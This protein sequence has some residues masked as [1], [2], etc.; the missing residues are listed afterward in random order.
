MAKLNKKVLLSFLLFI[1]IGVFLSSCSDKSESKPSK[2]KKIVVTSVSSSELL[3][4]LDVDDVIGVPESS[5]YSLPDRYK[6]KEVIGGPMSP[7]MEKIASLKP[8]LIIS[9]KSLESSLKEKYDNLGIDYRFIN[10]STVDGMYDSIDE[11]GVLLDREEEAKKLRS[12]YESKLESINKKIGNKEKPKVLVLMGVPG[13]YLV[14]TESS[15]VGDLVRLAGGENVYGDG[16]GVDFLNINTEDMVQKKADII[17][18]AAHGAPEQVNAM[19]KREFAE[20]DIWKHFDAVKNNK[21]YDLNIKKFGMSATLSYTEA[22]D[23]LEGLLF[24]K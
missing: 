22:L 14:A 15:Y 5:T 17:L 24:E 12:D 3:D 20:N 1:C 13:S 11:L 9:P 2:Y 7:D 4:K 21:V 10:L 23:E 19:F 6:D 16:N 18:R 8:D